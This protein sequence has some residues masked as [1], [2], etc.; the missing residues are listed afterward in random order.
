MGKTI[1]FYNIGIYR[2]NELTNINF[3]NFID[4]ISQNKW[5]YQVRKI[6]NEVVAIFPMFF[7]DSHKDMRIIPFGKFRM[8]Y[9]PFTGG[10]ESPKYREIKDDVVELVTLVYNSRYK[11]IAMD[12]NTY[13]AK[14][15]LIEHYFTSFL[16]QSEGEIWEVRM[17]EVITTFNEDELTNSNQVRD[18]EICL[19]FSKSQ[20]R[21]IKNGISIKNDC[22]LNTFGGLKEISDN[23]SANIIRLE[24]GALQNKKAAIKKETLLYLLKA[25]NI[26]S[27]CI[28]SVKVRY[29]NN[30]EKIETIDLKNINTILRTRVLDDVQDR[31]PAPEFLGNTVIETFESYSGT[32]LNSYTKFIEDSI[33]FN[34]IPYI[35]KEPRE[36]NKI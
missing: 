12:F 4:E 23:C 2:N 31:N 18:I 24:L 9:K 28:E 33:E 20:E 17:E 26:D 27:D 25:L 34:D 36:L 16:P 5:E 8:N 29:R 6:E 13:G 32:L 14:K 11:T 1:Y 7:N 21:Y 10:I 15:K 35:F 19:N 3:I 22:L 30:K